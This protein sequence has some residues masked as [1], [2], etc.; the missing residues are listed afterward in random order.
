V[1]GIIVLQSYVEDA[2]MVR[3]EAGVLLFLFL[4]LVR[5]LRMQP[6][7]LREHNMLEEHGLLCCKE[8]LSLIYH[9]C[10]KKVR[11]RIFILLL[12]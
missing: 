11:E 5:Q 10:D 2:A 4:A 7:T 6:F 9:S 3:P 12:C 8:Y 1:F